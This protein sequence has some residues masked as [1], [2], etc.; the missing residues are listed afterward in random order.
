MTPKEPVKEVAPIISEIE[1]PNTEV[2]TSE[3]T[4]VKNQSTEEFIESIGDKAREV[5]QEYNLYAS[6]MIAQA[7]LETGSGTS[8]LSQSPNYNLLV[9][10]VLTKDNQLIFIQMKIMEKV[11]F[12][13][14]K[15]HLENTQVIKN[16]LKIMLNF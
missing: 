11:N 4:V 12:I 14:F 1:Q 10:K 2:S 13:R 3:I 15:H 6:V 16:L 8:K 9:S 7:I 5:G